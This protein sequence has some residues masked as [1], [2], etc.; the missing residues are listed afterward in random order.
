MAGPASPDG[1]AKP[2]DNPGRVSTGDFGG[3]T[4]PNPSGPGRIEP[5]T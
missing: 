5:N 2:G 1:D 3:Y 4:G